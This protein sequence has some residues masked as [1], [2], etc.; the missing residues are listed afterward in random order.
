MSDEYPKHRLAK[1]VSDDDSVGA[2]SYII[3]KTGCIKVIV[4]PEL[5][6]VPDVDLP[7]AMPDNVGR[8]GALAGVGRHNPPQ[9]GSFIKVRIEDPYLRE[10]YYAEGPLGS[11]LYPYETAVGKIHITGYTPP[12]YPEPRLT[13]LPDGSVIFWDSKTGDMGIQ[14][15]SGS[16]IFLAATG[17][18]TIETAGNLSL[19]ANGQ[20]L[21]NLIKDL[22]SILD[23]LKTFGSP[24]QH[25]ISPD[26]KALLDALKINYNAIVQP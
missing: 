19:I 9:V 22:I 1:V 8:D 24:P 25:V 15:R 10:I 12:A 4:Y 5:E 13:A 26:T 3:P 17:Q 2:P 16:Y 21:S 11:A 14:H 18:G 23:G 6:G 7:W 20:S